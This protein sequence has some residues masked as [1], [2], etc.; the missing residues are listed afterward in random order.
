MK[1]EWDR[2]TWYSKTLAVILFVLLI[3]GTFWFGGWY[4][5]QVAMSQVSIG[6][7]P[8]VGDRVP[9]QINHTSGTDP[10]IVPSVAVAQA[11]PTSWEAL[12]PNYAYSNASIEKNMQ[13][14]LSGV[15]STTLSI[16]ACVQAAMEKY[17]VL[18][19]TAYGVIGKDI[20]DSLQNNEAPDKPSDMGDK[21]LVDEK[22]NLT[23]SKNLFTQYRVATC[24]AAYDEALGGTIG[25]QLYDGCYI[26]VT[27]VQIQT[28]CSTGANSSRCDG[29]ISF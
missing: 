11:T 22:N 14:C 26:S 24:T 3:A 18:L 23:K 1:I 21:A 20:A 25:G 13:H 5:T 17:D 10:E 28:L 4:Q 7:G 27:R 15:E 16:N 9:L 29:K 19:D 12:P 2:V 8:M 6:S